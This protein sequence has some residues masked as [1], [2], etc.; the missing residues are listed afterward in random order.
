MNDAWDPRARRP[1]QPRQRRDLLEE[2][3]D[4]QRRRAADFLTRWNIAHHAALSPNT[5]PGAK[6]QMTGNTGLAR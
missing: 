1:A 3:F 4:R 2:L 6:R 5:C